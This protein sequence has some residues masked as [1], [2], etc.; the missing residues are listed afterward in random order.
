M[1][2]FSEIVRVDFSD[3]EARR[4]EMNAF[5]KKYT[6]YINELLPINSVQDNGNFFLVNAAFFKGFLEKPFDVKLTEYQNFYGASEGLIEMM[7]T[8]GSFNYGL[9]INNQ[10]IMREKCFKQLID[11]SS[12]SLISSCS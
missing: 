10:I 2:T 11:K 4:A 9:F 8:I 3:P 12:I 7:Y 1:F 6:K 5:V